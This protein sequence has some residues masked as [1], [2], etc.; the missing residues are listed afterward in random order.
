MTI[1][2]ETL[3]LLD[4]PNV[5]VSINPELGEN[6]M[7]FKFKG[8]FTTEASAL[9]TKAWIKEFEDNKDKVY[10][11]LWD[12]TQMSD[13][14]FDAKNNWVKTLADYSSQIN[15]IAIVSNSILI[16]GTARVMS[17]FSKLRLLTYRSFEDVN[18]D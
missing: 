4:S 18:L 13:F 8:K 12:C 5:D 3:T 16:R 15:K 9:S 14:D 1:E 17:K 11:H 6:C 10:T 2:V 7:H